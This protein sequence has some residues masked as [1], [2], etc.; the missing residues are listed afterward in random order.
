[1]HQIDPCLIQNLRMLKQ[2]YDG[3]HLKKLMARY[4]N[5]E[6]DDEWLSLTWEALEC[7]FEEVHTYY[8]R[9]DEIGTV[10]FFDPVITEFA[11]LCRRCEVE[12]EN[13]PNLAQ[14]LQSAYRGLDECFSLDSY[15]YGYRLPEKGRERL[16]F[17]YG[18]EFCS[19]EELPGALAD[20]YDTMQYH[21]DRL[22][23]AL[24]QREK[25]IQLPVTEMEK[26]AA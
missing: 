5:A 21:T 24:S 14:I 13:D 10:V 3:G 18:E 4:E 25:V 9:E 2:L 8:N 15:D 1:M 20:A 19:E 12:K 16:V 6:L 22:R 11:R 23:N 26:E 17:L 7:V